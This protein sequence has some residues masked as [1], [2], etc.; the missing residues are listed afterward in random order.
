MLH[1]IFSIIL[2]LIVLVVFESSNKEYFYSKT[3]DLPTLF[4]KGFTKIKDLKDYTKKIENEYNAETPDLCKDKKIPSGWSCFKK[5]VDFT[6][7]WKKDDNNKR[8][9]LKHNYTQ[10]ESPP[11]KT[12]NELNEEIIPNLPGLHPLVKHTFNIDSLYKLQHN[13]KRYLR[14]SK[15]SAEKHSN[16]RGGNKSP[17]EIRTQYVYDTK[18]KKII[19]N[20]ERRGIDSNNWENRTKKIYW[21]GKCFSGDYDKDRIINDA[22]KVHSNSDY[23]TYISNSLN[24]L[25]KNKKQIKYHL[26]LP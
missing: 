14:I 4:E 20:S 15:E 17:F 16:E 5:D 3:Y 1:I 9:Y 24:H 25:D 13:P 7:D 19:S 11:F 21:L 8:F 22:T 23:N 26:K 10:E 18:Q 6:T 12:E 2:F